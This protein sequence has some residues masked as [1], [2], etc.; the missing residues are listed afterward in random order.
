ME[1]D[2]QIQSIAQTF[3]GEN[4]FPEELIHFYDSEQ[5]L[6]YMMEWERTHVEHG[7]HENERDL[8]RSITIAK[9]FTFAQIEKTK[10]FRDI[11]RVVD[12]Q[13]YEE[14]TPANENSER[15]IDKDDQQNRHARKTRSRILIL[16][17]IKTIINVIRHLLDLSNGLIFKT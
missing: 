8:W 11:M 2:R 16:T 12:R 3:F 17:L 5:N 10:K 6:R 1:R 15:I 4:N 13:L 14:D 9:R 7:R